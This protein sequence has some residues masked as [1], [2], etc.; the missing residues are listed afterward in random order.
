SVDARTG[1][2]SFIGSPDFETPEDANHDNVYDL[3]VSA[4]D[5]FGASNNQAI[6][7]TVANLAESGRTFEGGNGNDV[8]TGTTGNDTMNGGNK[9]ERLNANDDNDKI[10]GG[11]GDDILIGG[12]GNDLLE[13]GNG[14]DTFAFA[15]S[16]GHDI[17]SDFHNGDRIEFDG[18]V[19]QDFHAVA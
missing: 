7:V 13:G 10:I 11:N 8:L 12:R 4:T 16:F 1:A 15:K 5:A 2:L 17:V 3:V 14:S 18:G 9:N 19:F 6:H